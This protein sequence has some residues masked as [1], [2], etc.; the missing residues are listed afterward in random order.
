MFYTN[1][2][3]LTIHKTQGSKNMAFISRNIKKLFRY[4]FIIVSV[5]LLSTIIYSVTQLIQTG[6]TAK[7]YKTDYAELHSV[8]YGMF[9]SDIWRSKIIK[10][11]D[12][13]IETFA[14]DTNNRE[15]I[16]GYI[17]TI[18][19]TL[20]LEADR[21]V[22]ERNQGKRGFFDSLVGST[23]QMITDSLIDIKKLRNRVPEFTNAV[24]AEV[25]KPENQARAKKVIREKLKQFTHEK[26][27]LTTDMTLFNAVLKRYNAIDL[28]TCN[29][30]LDAHMQEISEEMNRSMILILSLAALLIFFILLQGKLNSIS[31]L[32]LS[33]TSITLLIPGI[34]LPMLDI[35]AKIS[36][37]YFTILDKSII[38]E[39]QIL[40]FQSKS[41]S[42][43]VRLLLESDEGKMI[44]VGVLLTTF[45]II[46]PTIK[47]IS[48]Y[49]YYYSSS[50]IGNNPVTRFFA[51]RSTKWSMADVMVV[52]IFMA[53]L[54]LDGVV[55][56]ELT[57]LKAST[58]PIN[59][60]T[61]NHTHLEVGFFLFLGFVATSFVLSILVERTRK[62]A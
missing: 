29:R 37:L 14:L 62:N 43:L 51:L 9:N 6:N 40:F 47:L 60:I 54:G 23:K 10:I 5:I 30:I 16:R 39:N 32:M 38:F 36:K 41:I 13:K 11:I 46:F 58:A 61:T 20:I 27:K 28:E 56:N 48:S 2:A 44:F 42:D 15:E 3:I 49:M 57:R 7:V 52:S 1:F 33:A 25:E 17:E 12:Q 34:M 8:Q 4:W 26:F 22:R 50:I 53:Y 45:S 18:L 31:L 59:V 19:D 35:E 55:N 21:V 24:M